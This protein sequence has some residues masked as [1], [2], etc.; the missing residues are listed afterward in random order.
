MP[1]DLPDRLVVGVDMPFRDL[2]ISDNGF[3][4]GWNLP[5]IFLGELAADGISRAGASCKQHDLPAA[6]DIF[7]RNSVVRK[8]AEITGPPFTQVLDAAEFV[9]QAIDEDVVRRQQGTDAL[10]VVGIDSVEECE[11]DLYRL[12]VFHGGA[13][14]DSSGRDCSKAEPNA[15]QPRGNIVPVSRLCMI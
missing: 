15:S 12:F 13:F 2:T 6:E 8:P 3:P 7:V 5:A 1:H 14:H 9:S 10:D 11:N 4:S